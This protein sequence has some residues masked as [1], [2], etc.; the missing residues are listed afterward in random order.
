MEGD[1]LER[2]WV[3]LVS[4]EAHMWPEVWT[5]EAGRSQPLCFPRALRAAPTVASW[6]YP[7]GGGARAQRTAQKRTA[8]VRF[9][10]QLRCA[11]SPT[12]VGCRRREL[13]RVRPKPV[14]SLVRRCAC[15]HCALRVPLSTMS[16]SATR[17]FPPASHAS[18]AACAVHNSR[19]C[20]RLGLSA[21][22]SGCSSAAAQAHSHPSNR[23]ASGT[24]CR[25]TR[26]RCALHDAR[27]G[28]RV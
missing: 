20:A 1:D 19:V 10:A 18:C 15:L 27:Q 28:W 23:L 17:C 4:G 13:R 8:V 26:V 2:N 21:P 5:T 12:E 22:P 7:T 6:E 9:T 25:M 14:S 24:R 11:Q 3:K 16:A